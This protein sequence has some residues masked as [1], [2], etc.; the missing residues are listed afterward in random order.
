MVKV[1]VELCKSNS[2]GSHYHEPTV[3][4]WRE[5]TEEEAAEL[6]TKEMANGYFWRRQPADKTGAL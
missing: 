1:I 5:A 4:S 2:I 6:C 3:K